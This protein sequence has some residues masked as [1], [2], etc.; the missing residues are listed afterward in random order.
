MAKRRRRFF[1][2]EYKAEV[3]GLI[4]KRGKSVGAVARLLDLTETAVRR[5]LKQGEIDSGEAP[6]GALT[7]AER[8]ELAALHKRVKT[9]EMERE[10][11]KRAT[12]GS[13]GR[14]I[15]SWSQA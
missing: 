8:E 1:T 2:E 14:Y 6:G 7:A 4:R 5:R 15:I 10:I 12:A 3:V 11:L 13:M 9:L